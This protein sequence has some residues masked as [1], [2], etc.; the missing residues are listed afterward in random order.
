MGETAAPGMV[1]ACQARILSD[2]HIEAEEVPEVSH[3]N[4]QVIGL[5]QLASD[6][7]EV[8]IRPE[9]RLHYLPGQY[10][11]FDCEGVSNKK[12]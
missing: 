1:H 11:K 3:A 8:T 10:C 12:L 5:R 9:R 7:T 6:V 4:A 2:V